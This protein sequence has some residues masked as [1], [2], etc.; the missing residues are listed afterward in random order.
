MP[1]SD[2]AETSKWADGAVMEPVCRK[3]FQLF[4]LKPHIHVRRQQ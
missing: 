4:S 3:P 2:A 1:A